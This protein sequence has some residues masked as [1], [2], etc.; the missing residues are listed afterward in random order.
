M[1]VNGIQNPQRQE[2]PFSNIPPMQ[3]LGINNL[4]QLLMVCFF[5]NMTY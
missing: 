5:I 1:P 3:P 4:F 2:R